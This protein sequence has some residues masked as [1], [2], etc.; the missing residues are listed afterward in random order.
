MNGCL[1]CLLCHQLLEVSTCPEID[2]GS[3]DGCC[4]L[5]EDDYP[6]CGSLCRTRD[7]ES[8]GSL[9]RVHSGCHLLSVIPDGT[10]GVLHGAKYIWDSS[11]ETNPEEY[12]LVISSSHFSL[13]SNVSAGMRCSGAFRVEVNLGEGQVDLSP[14]N[15]CVPFHHN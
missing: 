3:S 14:N 8:D 15:Q 4:W 5:W 13:M 1:H 2:E 9:H 11:L 10:S 6:N 7:A 12:F